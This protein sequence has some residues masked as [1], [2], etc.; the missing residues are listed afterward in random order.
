VRYALG[1]AGIVSA[2]AIISAIRVD[3]RVAVVG[4]IVM[5]VLMV[6]LVVFARLA[7]ATSDVFRRPI[8]VLVWSFL[9]ISIVTAACLFTSVFFRWPLNLQYWIDRQSSNA[10]VPSPSDTEA[11]FDSELRHHVFFHNSETKQVRGGFTWWLRPIVRD[12]TKAANVFLGLAVLHDESRVPPGSEPAATQKT[13]AEVPSCL[14]SKAWFLDANP[15]IVRGDSDGTTLSWI[16]DFPD[17]VRTIRLWW[18]FYQ[19]EADHGYKCQFDLTRPYPKDG[20]PFLKVVAENGAPAI[21]QGCYRSTDA[22]LLKV[23]Y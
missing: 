7:S 22:V 3:L 23:V 2:I 14:A 1:V 10:E 6:L 19:R 15:I 8:L 20:I 16:A 4:T 5:V 12:K 21:D 9:T 11:R 17:S 18:E 13:C